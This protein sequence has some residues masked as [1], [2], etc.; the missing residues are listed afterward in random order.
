MSGMLPC[1]IGQLAGLSGRVRC[2]C[3][4]WFWPDT[5][6]QKFCDH[7]CYSASIR[8][9][10]EQ[11]FWTKVNKQGPAPAHLPDLSGCWL[12]TAATIRGYG[13]ILGVL[14]GKRRPLYAHRVSWELAFG[15]ILNDLEVLHR[16]DTP[17]CVRPDHLFLGTQQDNLADA[18]AKGRLDN[19]KPRRRRVVLPMPVPLTNVERVPTVE[20]PIY[21]L[22]DLLQAPRQFREAVQRVVSHATHGAAVVTKVH[23]NSIVAGDR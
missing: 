7:A 21:E 6:K 13:Q 12:W 10:I 22:R 19:S 2:A 16:C 1:P 3:G 9:P 23:S 4:R 20:L 17:L 8:V 18:R 15:P 11:R 14:N 5:P